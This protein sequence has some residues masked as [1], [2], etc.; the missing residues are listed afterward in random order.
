MKSGFKNGW[1]SV[2]R[3]RLRDKSVTP[4]CIFSKV[5]S[6]GNIPGNTPV[7]LNV[8]DLTTVNGYMY[9]AGLGIF[10][11]GVEV[12]G[13]EYAFG[14]HDYPTSGVFEVE[15][16]Q[17]PGF[18]FR[19][20]VFMGT[21]NLD[22]FQIREFMERQSANYNG[23]TYHLIVKNCNHFC[24]D[25]CYKLTGTSIPK[26]VNRLAR[27]GS[28]CNCILPDALKTST[29]EHDPNFQGCDSEKRRL[30]TAFSCLSSISMPHKEVSMSS[31]FMHSHYK[32]CL[33]PW[34][35]KKSKK[36]RLKQ[37]LEDQFTSQ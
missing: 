12:Y 3:L 37:K 20:S 30:R 9:W 18:K 13:V 31:L 34:E 10:H 21:T 33:P 24:E 8:Y 26:W 22:P 14:A 5:K 7:Y 11:S 25:I 17:C 15:P 1:P 2:V 4:F 16:R 35:L 32:G 6:A 28:F 29:V 19:K 36:G 23:D 27:I